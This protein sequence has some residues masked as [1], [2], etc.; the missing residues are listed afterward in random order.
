VS[1]PIIVVM[2]GCLKTVAK[3][4]YPV[5][6]IESGACGYPVQWVVLPTYLNGFAE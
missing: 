4:E 1:C 3:F 5:P 2:F 6:K